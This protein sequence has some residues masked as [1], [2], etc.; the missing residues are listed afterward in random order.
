MPAHRPKWNTKPG[1]F[2]ILD[3]ENAMD[4]MTPSNGLDPFDN[5]ILNIPEVIPVFPLSNVVLL[6]GEVLPLHIFEP[7][8]RAMVRDSISGHRIIGMVEY[9]S[10]AGD[11]ALPPIRKV[12]CAG[13]IA[14]HKELPDG[15]FL[16]WLLGLERFTIDEELPNDALYRR[17]RVT[18]TP[19][20]EKPD[21]LAGLLPVRNELHRILPRFVDLDDDDRHTLE[22]QMADITDSQLIALACQI[23]E[24][25]GARKRELLEATNHVERY[26]LLYEDL[27]QHLDGNPLTDRNEPEIFN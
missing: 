23:L 17:A 24:L 12:G 16:I 7:R 8:Y 13:F 21:S 14:E 1:S 15:R 11:E 5:G 26:M 25:P 18:Y 20:H 27:Y 19:I 6:P 9:Q 4:G 10:D 22:I 2:V 3:E